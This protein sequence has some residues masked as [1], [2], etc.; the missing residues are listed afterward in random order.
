MYY[1]INV[2]K[3]GKHF[4]ATHERSITT[5]EQLI[6]ALDCFMVKFPTEEGYEL[7]LSHH[8]QSSKG[9]KVPTDE[10]TLRNDIVDFVMK[11]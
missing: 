11:F 7:R 2:S 6:E 10:L 8:I 3:N 5:K 1:E 4:F 9:C